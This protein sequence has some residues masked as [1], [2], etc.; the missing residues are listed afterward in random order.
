MKL[1]ATLRPRSDG[2][3]ILTEGKQR[4]VFAPC[5]DHGGLPV[6][7]IPDELA[8]KMLRFKHFEPADEKDYER[9]ND[10]MAAAGVSSP[11]ESDQDDD[12]DGD[13]LVNGGLPAE[14]GTPP[15]PSTKGPGKVLAGNRRRGR[16]SAT[17]M[18]G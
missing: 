16:A 17:S 2:T 6:A 13:E 5:A 12:D 4:Y 10:L 8:G 18:G 7:D 11:V 15:K 3:V 9:A 14:A 1:L